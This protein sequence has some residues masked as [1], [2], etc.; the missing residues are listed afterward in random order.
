MLF[1]REKEHEQE[2]EQ[3]EREREKQT[4]HGARYLTWGSVPGCWDH[5]LR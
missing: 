1:E 3:R 5:D 4:P 2:E